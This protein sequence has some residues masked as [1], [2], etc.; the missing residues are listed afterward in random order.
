MT[1]DFEIIAAGKNITTTLAG[2]LLALTV[3]DEA[4]MS[5]DQVKITLDDRGGA[6]ALPTPGAPLIVAL[7]YRETGIIPMGAFT[8]DEVTLKGP[9]DVMEISGKAADMGGT[10]KDQK[11][12]DW[13]NVTIGAMVAKIAA[14]HGLKHR[15]GGDLAQIKLDHIDQTAESDLNLLIRIGRDNDA[16]VTVKGGAILFM[17]K[18]T[19]TT[20]SGTPL[21]PVLVGRTGK[22]TWSVTR[23][24]RGKF[25][26]VIA[27]YHDTAA[28]AQ[29]DVQAGQGTPVKRLTHIYSDQPTAQRAARAALGEMERGNDTLTITM[30]GNPM[31]TAAGLITAAGFRPG[32]DGQWSVTSVTHAI[33]ASGYKTTLKAETPKK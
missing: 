12:R 30:P 6:I 9:P 21:A 3:T 8:A 24:T 7:G 17:P 1:P 33:T 23:S 4:G 28:G 29:V 14:E 11:T 26:A 32:I 22:T 15:V 5:A 20:A 19:G 27:T 31:I 2:R 13:D 10:I 25:A 18:G 16:I